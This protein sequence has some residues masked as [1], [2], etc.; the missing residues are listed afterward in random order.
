MGA[1][2]TGVVECYECFE[3]VASGQ[4]YP[5]CAGKYRVCSMACLNTYADYCRLGI[6][7]SVENNPDIYQRPGWWTRRRWGP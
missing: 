6:R 5:I 7:A 1:G 4:G 3:P 2:T